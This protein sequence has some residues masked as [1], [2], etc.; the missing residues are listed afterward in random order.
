M[1]EAQSLTRLFQLIALGLGHRV[2]EPINAVLPGLQLTETVEELV[3]QWKPTSV[4]A[5]PPRSA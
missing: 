5:H 3:C 4:N 2:G 1:A